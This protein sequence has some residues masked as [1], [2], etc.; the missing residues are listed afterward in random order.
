M[1]DIELRFQ[2]IES[3]IAHSQKMIDD[4]NDVVIQQAKKIDALVK[5]NLQIIEL[6]NQGNVKSLDEEIPPPHY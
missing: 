3:A 2:S 4:I 6:L 5:R 1:Q